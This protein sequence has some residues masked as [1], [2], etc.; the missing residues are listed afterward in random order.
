[1]LAAQPRVI[2]HTAYRQHDAS[3][4]VEGTRAVVAAAAAALFA[5]RS[6]TRYAVEQLVVA[7]TEAAQ[8]LERA[9]VPRE[10]LREEALRVLVRAP[11]FAPAG[12][13]GARPL[14]G[15]I[16]VHRADALSSGPGGTAVAHVALT[17]ELATG[18]GE[19]ALRE[20]G[21]AAEPIGGG[22]EAL[23]GALDRAARSALG[24][25]VGAFSL[26]VEAARKRTADLLK[27]LDSPEAR[28]RDQAVRALADRGER[29]AVPGLIARLKDPDAEVRERA[30]GALAQ[31]GDPRAVP[32]L[33]EL[34]RRR[35]AP[36]VA[37]LARLVG[38]IGGDDA[39]AWLLT[40]SSGH[41]DD[42]VRGAATEALSELAARDLARQA[43]AAKRAP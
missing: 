2:I 4:N 26:Q 41:P 3:V 28:V 19:L 10:A 29:A 40:L 17:L 16:I 1:V 36:Y 13:R 37:N 31:L 22:S 34:A 20:T 24:R 6:R 14:V 33:I 43:S 8:R 21:R 27:D 11:G 18:E 5:C 38:D 25:V 39:R 7:D 15:Q 30:V 32:A 42:V 12:A 35:D 23:R 9:G